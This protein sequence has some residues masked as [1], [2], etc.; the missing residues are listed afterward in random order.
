VTVIAGGRGLTHRVV[1]LAGAAQPL[2]HDKPP[3]GPRPPLVAVP[4][5]QV[6]AVAAFP[7]GDLVDQPILEFLPPE[8][9]GLV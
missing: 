5:R 3:Q 1:Q 8:P 9:A 6:A 4:R 2:V 7:G